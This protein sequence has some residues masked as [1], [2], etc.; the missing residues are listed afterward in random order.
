[1]AR[2]KTKAAQNSVTTSSRK[3]SPQK[4]SAPKSS[5]KK[6]PTQQ[7]PPSLAAPNSYGGR[8]ENIGAGMRV[9]IIGAGGIANA[10]FKGH[11]HAGASIVA[12]AEPF[13]TTRTRRESEWNARGFSSVEELLAWGE[14]D[15]VSICTP[16]AFHASASILAMR[17]GKHVLCEK[18]LSMSLRDCQAMIDVAKQRKLILQTGHHLRANLLVEK[19]K[20]IIQSGAL[21][22]V[23]F[24]RLRQAHDWGGNKSISPGFALFKNSG[25][26]TLLDNGCHMMDLARNLGGNVSSVYCKMGT[27]G[28]WT[29]TVEVED[30]SLV[31]L[32]FESGAIASVENAWT[33]IGWEEGFWIY[34][35]EGALECSNRTGPR[36]LRHAHRSSQGTDWATLDETNYSFVDEGGHSREIAMFWRSIRQGTPVICTGQDGLESVRLVLSSYESAKKGKPIKL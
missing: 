1:M 19:A 5:A 31:T 13:E 7:N 18:P 24:M 10:H 32:E 15:A 26:G 12:F 3:S 9:A 14:F 25:G 16:N 34:G 20:E 36:T 4:S 2:L 27:L 35:T 23:T 21:G 28:N 11:S 29:N 30:T 33:A 8:S 22:R 6:S 17:A